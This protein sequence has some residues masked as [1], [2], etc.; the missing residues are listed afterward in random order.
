[1]VAAFILSRVVPR[2]LYRRKKI[3]DEADVIQEGGRKGGR[4]GEGEAV[5][6]TVCQQ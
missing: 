2:C 5:I 1:M 6:T 3:Q 4:M